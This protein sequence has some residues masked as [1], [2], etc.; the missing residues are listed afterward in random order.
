MMNLFVYSDNEM[1]FSLILTTSLS[2]IGINNP[3]LFDGIDRKYYI[4][5]GYPNWEP[6]ERKIMVGM[7]WNF[8]DTEREQNWKA[9][10]QGWNK[11]IKQLKKEGRY[12]QR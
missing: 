6:A 12:K 9:I 1:L 3:C 11:F 4:A 2:S 8:I 10:S 7:D 5:K